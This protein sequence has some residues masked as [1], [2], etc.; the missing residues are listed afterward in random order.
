MEGEIKSRQHEG[1]KQR[2][3][4]HWEAAPSLPL[5]PVLGVPSCPVSQPRQHIMLFLTGGGVCKMQKEQRKLILQPAH[6][7]LKAGCRDIR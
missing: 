6:A 7:L 3:D 1:S 2:G 4:A 5:C